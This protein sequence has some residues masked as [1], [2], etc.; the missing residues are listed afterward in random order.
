MAKRE[1]FFG[2]ARDHGLIQE[3]LQLEEEGEGGVPVVMVYDTLVVSIRAILAELQISSIP[4][5]LEYTI[6][7]DA[8]TLFITLCSNYSMKRMPPVED[9]QKLARFL[10]QEPMWC[11]DSTHWRWT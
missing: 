5:R 10:G 6:T 1:F 3:G 8:G 9:V 11:F 2:Y 4:I 7:R